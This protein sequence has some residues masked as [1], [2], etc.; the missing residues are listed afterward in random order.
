MNKPRSCAFL[1]GNHRMVT[2]PVHDV[3]IL[4]RI[5]LCVVVMMPD[6]KRIT[7]GVELP[8]VDG[9]VAMSTADGKFS[10]EE[11]KELIPP[12]DP[13]RHRGTSIESFHHRRSF[14]LRSRTTATS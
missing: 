14:Q 10:N 2:T 12:S 8:R 3:D 11:L 4:D 1:F 13:N 9:L 6:H 7:P 5:V